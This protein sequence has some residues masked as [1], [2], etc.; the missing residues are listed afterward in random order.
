MKKLILFVFCFLT[1]L[2]LNNQ[3]AYAQIFSNC[4]NNEVED[5]NGKC[6]NLWG[7]CKPYIDSN[8]NKCYVDN[9]NP[10]FGVVGCS[11]FWG[12]SRDEYPISVCRPK[13]AVQPPADA[14]QPQSGLDNK[15]ITNVLRD[16]CQDEQECWDRVR[17]CIYEDNPNGIVTVALIEAC[18]QSFRQYRSTVGQPA[19]ARPAVSQSILNCKDNECFDQS[20]G[21]C[22]NE[23]IQSC[24]V[25]G[26]QKIKTASDGRCIFESCVQPPTPSTCQMK[27]EISPDF[28][29]DEHGE[30]SYCDPDAAEWNDGC[31]LPAPAQSA[32]PVG[33]LICEREDVSLDLCS[34]RHG[35]GSVCNAANKKFDD[36]CTAPSQDR[37]QR[38]GDPACAE[39]PDESSAYT[40]CGQTT[41]LEDYPADHVILVT[42][43]KNCR[44]SIVRYDNKDKGQISGLCGFSGRQDQGQTQRPDPPVIKKVL[45]YNRPVIEFPNGI[46]RNVI[47][48]EHLCQDTIPG[49]KTENI[50]AQTLIPVTIKMLDG[51]GREIEAYRVTLKLRIKA[52]SQKFCG[53]CGGKNQ[54][55]CKGENQCNPGGGNNTGSLCTTGLVCGTDATTG[56]IPTCRDP[57]EVG[58]KTGRCTNDRGE[59]MIVGET[60]CNNKK[61]RVECKCDSQ[62]CNLEKTGVCAGFSYNDSGAVGGQCDQTEFLNGHPQRCIS[63]PTGSPY[64]NDPNKGEKRFRQCFCYSD[65][66]VWTKDNGSCN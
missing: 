9:F 49:C 56:K 36:G 11:S 46:A 1:L 53:S 8:D 41:G 33:G 61:E 42:P 59:K 39:T 52:N 64:E 23:G 34:I 7:A 63:I 66:C 58:E 44:G 15:Q 17:R 13:K 2:S 21:R 22:R 60:T 3:N 16:N 12:S 57:Q 45:I 19:P 6:H 40:Q 54:P 35:V 62:G 26:T 18:T 65:G 10:F 55:C 37:G 20:V 32:V 43:I 48:L 25:N 27:K 30:S 14:G 4:S 28:C 47:N 24:G 5:I 51:N 50:T 31:T 38:T 29:S